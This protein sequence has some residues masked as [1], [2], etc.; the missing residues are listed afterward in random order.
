MNVYSLL[1]YFKFRTLGLLLFYTLL[2]GISYFIAFQLRFDFHVPESFTTDMIHTIWWI[3]GLKLTLLLAFGQVDCV[4]SYFR[5]SDA[6]QLFMGLFFCNAFLVVLWYSY[7]GEGMPPR[8]II[9]T[10]FFLCFLLLAGFR[11]AMRIRASSDLNDWLNMDKIENVIIVGAGEVGAGIC[12]ELKN[13]T[14][15]GLLPVALLDDDTNKIGRY[16]HGVRIAGSVDQLTTVAK[17]YKAQ[18]VIIAFPSA[19]KRRMREVVEMAQSMQMPVES[20]PAMT[21]LVSGRAKITQLHPIEM[22][23]LLGRKAVDLDS[24]HINSMLSGKRVLVTGAGGSIGREL[25]KQILDYA[26]DALLCID[27]SEIAIFNLRQ[28]ILQ[29]HDTGD[30]AQTLVLNICLSDEMTAVFECFKPDIIF[31]A[32]AHKHVNLMEL[33]PVEALRNNF[34]ATIMLTRLASRFAV[35]RFILISTDKAINPCS[36]MGVS[37]RLAE[38]AL[39]EQQQASD[40]HTQFMAVRFGNVLGSSGSVIQIFKRQIAEGGP[41][42][43]TDSK[44]T[45]FFMTVQEA[46][47]LVLQSATQGRGGEILVLNMGEPVKIID[48]ARQMIALSGYQEGEDIE[49]V[50]TG[51]KPGEKLHEEVQH[52]NETLQPTDHPLVMRFAAERES[53]APVDSI[54]AELSSAFLSN[55]VD[56]IKR[57]IQKYV[58]EYTPYTGT[59]KNLFNCVS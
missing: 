35:N 32:A 21:D 18:K 46:V 13:K 25:I 20:V 34:F 16:V 2:C 29:T 50:L 26:P 58:P 38:L 47:G 5:L 57:M 1:N 10:D 42:T 15:F 28:E 59:S 3:V 12:S 7:S 23:D 40:N 52:L 6:L 17:R 33:Q 49:I 56:H 24:K 53:T 44:V 19:S 45:R 55:D 22:K 4:L 41:L 31:H 14:R 30:V 27:Q 51:L 36:I 39:L 37:K 43:V 11:V 54:H 8:A 48:I 9:L